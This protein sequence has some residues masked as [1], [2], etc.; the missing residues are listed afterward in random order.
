MKRN[1]WFTYCGS[2][3]LMFAT[4]VCARAR[5]RAFYSGHLALVSSSCVFVARVSPNAKRPSSPPAACKAAFCM[6]KLFFECA[7]RTVA[8]GPPKLPL[9]NAFV[10]KGE[11]SNASP[12]TTSPLHNHQHPPQFRQHAISSINSPSRLV[13]RSWPQPQ[14]ARACHSR[15]LA[16]RQGALPRLG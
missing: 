8:T 16:R 4:C 6:S 14:S 15:N 11:H 13:A 2:G 5:A 10:S 1:C 9:L 7:R 12:L 3:G